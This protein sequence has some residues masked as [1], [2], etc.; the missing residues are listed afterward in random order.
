MTKKRKIKIEDIFSVLQEENPEP[1][2]EEEEPPQTVK[3]LDKDEK[4]VSRVKERLR[5][6]KAHRE[7]KRE[8]EIGPKPGLPKYYSNEGTQNKNCS[9]LRCKRAK[10]H[11]DCYTYKTKQCLELHDK[12][13]HLQ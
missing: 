9:A 12:L 6:R 11:N 5:I 3:L 13:N 8:I 7:R 2:W 10:C 4:K 1:L